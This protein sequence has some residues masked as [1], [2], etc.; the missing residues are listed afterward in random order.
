MSQHLLMSL[1]KTIDEI[2]KDVRPCNFAEFVSSIK[3]TPE[4]QRLLIDQKKD[5]SMSNIWFEKRKDRITASILKSA[6]IKL[7]GNSKMMIPDK[8]R[9]ILSKVYSYYPRCKSKATYWGI[10]NEPGARNTYVKT[11]KKKH[12]NFKVEQTGFHV[13]V[14]HPHIGASADGLAECDCH[15]P[16]LL[17]IKCP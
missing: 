7:D 10:S 8:P 6:V 13:H 5:Q 4:Q 11:M 3:M 2:S 14:E 12:Q 16:G 17:E 1:P 9:T 15:G